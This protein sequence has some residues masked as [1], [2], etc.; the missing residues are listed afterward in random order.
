MDRTVLPLFPYTIVAFPG[1]PVPLR[2]FEPRYKAMCEDIVG[3]TD[4]FGLVLAQSGSQFEHE[5]PLD[6]G[7]VVRIADHARLP[8]G[9][10]LVQAVGVRRFRVRALGPRQP[11]LTAEVETIEEDLG[12]DLR[13]YALRDSAVQRLRRLFAL[14]TE[15][16][17]QAL[18][19]SIELSAEPGAA[20][21]QIAAVMGLPTSA[22]QR[23]LEITADDDRLAAE[24]V[25]LEAAIAE[26]ERH[27]IGG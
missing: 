22:Q 7:T 21:Y 5:E 25:L 6:V 1:V 17:T 26:V 27:L 19:V 20:S 14:R 16:E 10:W 11:Y 23:V 8:D 4:E 9:Q 24:V 18:P 13:A 2:F 12:N 3:S 15:F